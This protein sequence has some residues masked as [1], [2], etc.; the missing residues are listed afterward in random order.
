MGRAPVLDRDNLNDILQ[1]VV[2]VQDQ[3]PAPGSK[4]EAEGP[5]VP[6]EFSTGIRKLLHY[7]KRTSYSIFGVMRKAVRDNHALKLLGRSQAQ[8]DLCH[9]LQLV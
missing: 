3:E 7:A 9:C 8:P 5:P 1:L 2:F 4:K 6:V